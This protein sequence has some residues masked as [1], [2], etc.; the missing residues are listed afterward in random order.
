[1]RQTVRMMLCATLGLAAAA[2]ISGA[3]VLV[4]HD[5]FEGETLDLSKWTA[6]TGLVRN[7]RAAQLYRNDPEN[8]SVSGG[9]LRLTATHA[10]EGYANPYFGKREDWRGDTASKAY[11]SGAVNSF[12]KLSMRYGRVEVR[13][14][15]GVASGVWPAIWMLGST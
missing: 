8:L 11:A 1:M 5:E 13:A 12:G 7:D 15:F 9:A 14:R 2:E 10:A 4:W 3:E 6:E